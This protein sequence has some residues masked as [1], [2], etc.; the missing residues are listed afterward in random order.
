MQCYDFTVCNFLNSK[1]RQPCLSCA[2][3]DFRQSPETAHPCLWLGLASRVQFS[4][5]RTSWEAEFLK[6]WEQPLLRHNKVIIFSLGL[7]I[8]VRK[9]NPINVN[10]LDRSR[11]DKTP[12]P[13]LVP[14][15]SL[16][17]DISG[18]YNSAYSVKFSSPPSFSPG[19]SP[20][21][22][23]PESFFKHQWNPSM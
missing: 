8:Q 1:R 21:Q 9:F 10:Q 4:T 15:I 14:D 13:D 16:C 12:V 23:A 3:K 7:F 19:L 2:N 17:T 20:F 18:I 6:T 5:C 22:M 11:T